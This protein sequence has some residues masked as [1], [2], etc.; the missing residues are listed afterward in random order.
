[1]IESLHVDILQAAYVDTLQAT[2][3]IYADA[4]HATALLYKMNVAGVLV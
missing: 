2:A 3:L 4:L 1:M